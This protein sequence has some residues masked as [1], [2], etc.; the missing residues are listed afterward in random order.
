MLLTQPMHYPQP[1][2][3]VQVGEGVLG[4][5]VTEVVLPASKDAIELA[6]EVGEWVVR[7][8]IDFAL[9]LAMIEESDFLDGQV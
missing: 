2:E 1:G 8:C 5:A 4:H 7:S 9:T 6:Q 3:L